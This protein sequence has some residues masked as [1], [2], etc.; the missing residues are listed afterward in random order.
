MR[1]SIN[2]PEVKVFYG[3]RK[4][5][6]LLIFGAIH[7]DEVCGVFA[8]KKL[9][10]NI[11]SGKIVLNMG[12]ITLVPVCNELAYKKKTRFVEENLNR[13]FKIWR[14][15]D[16]Y[17]K[18][19]ANGLVPLVK[20]CDII[21]DIHSM[22][23][24]GIPLIFV[25]FPTKSNVSFS[26]ILGVKYC[27]EGWPEL[28]QN[29]GQGI[30]S[31]DTMGYA[32]GLSKTSSVIEC[33]QNKDPNSIKIAYQAILNTLRHFDFI[34]G[35]VESKPLTYIVV[36]NL[37]LITNKKDVLS[38]KWNN[39]DGFKKGDVL[40]VRANGEKII[41]AFNGVIIFPNPKAKIGTEWFYLGTVK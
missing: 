26:R 3:K 8:I 30:A 35:T 9:I 41:A 1:K 14:R 12:S 2:K 11:E 25:D 36:K 22:E 7:G 5:P 6:A 13:V 20:S 40:A 16:S 21:L 23:A 31:Y 24:N 27:V 28:Y 39:F 38:R 18:Q 33:G 10:K 15:P 32:D 17:E 4:G 37:F 29:D 34:D 19:I